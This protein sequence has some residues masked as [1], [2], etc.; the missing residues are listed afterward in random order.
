LLDR[1]DMQIEIHGVPLRSLEGVSNEESSQ[2]VKERVN[3]ARQRQLQRYAGLGIYCNDQL[4][5]KGV[6]TFCQ[7]DQASRD[8]LARSDGRTLALTPR[9]YHRILKVAR[10]IT[11]LQGAEEITVDAVAEAMQYR[12]LDRRY[13]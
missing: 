7:A 11:D 8:L 12:A 13:W 2:N 6:E 1:F 9:A 10:T 5:T 3:A 4:D